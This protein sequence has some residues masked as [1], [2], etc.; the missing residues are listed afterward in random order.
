[1]TIFVDEKK[2]ILQPISNLTLTAGYSNQTIPVIADIQNGGFVRSIHLSNAA[3]GFTTTALAGLGGTINVPNGLPPG[4][5]VFQ[6]Y[7]KNAVGETVGRQT[8][9]VTVNAAP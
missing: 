3:T 6:V 7:A 8:V 1:V 4:P 9:T 2:P 5:Y